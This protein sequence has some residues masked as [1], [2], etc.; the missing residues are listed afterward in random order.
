MGSDQETMTDRPT[1]RP[2]DRKVV[3][4]KWQVSMY[5]FFYLQ[6]GTNHPLAA[7]PAIMLSYMA[8]MPRRQA[9]HK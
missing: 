4:L 8:A 2:T 1:N 3:L 9:L 5:N 7:F 6:S